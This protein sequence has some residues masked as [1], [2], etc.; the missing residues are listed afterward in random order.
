VVTTASQSLIAITK[1]NL[2]GYYHTARTEAL[3]PSTVQSA[4]RKTGI[5]PLDCQAILLSAFEPSKNMTVQAAQP[6]PAQLPSVL[7]PTPTPTPSAAAAN[8]LEHDV[9]IP[10]E[11]TDKDLDDEEP[12]QRYH[13][14]LTP[15]LPGTV[16]RKALRAENFML[17]DIIAQAGIALEEDFAQMKLMDLENERLRKWAFEKDARK[18]T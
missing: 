18:K 4:F 13:I 5:W 3:K 8:A 6:L 17:R 11:P 12:M 14:E 9:D 16:S 2:L 10:V 15:P 7:S 1:E